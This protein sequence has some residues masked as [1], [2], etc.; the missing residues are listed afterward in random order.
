MGCSD[1]VRARVATTD[2]K[3]V[4]ALGGD[5]LLVR[6]CHASQHAVLLREQFEGQM[7]ALQ[8]A[9]RSLEV[10]S[11]GCSGGNYDGIVIFK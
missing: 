11:S 3:N 1:T 7:H 9:A 6:E 10:A 8:F 5:A 2:N 4:L